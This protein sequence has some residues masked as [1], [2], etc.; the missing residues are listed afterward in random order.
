MF[1]VPHAST[2]LEWRAI[3]GD[4][5]A[6]H[7]PGLQQRSQMPATGANQAGQVL[8]QPG[9]APLPGPPTGQPPLLIQEQQPPQ[10]LRERIIVLQKGQQSIGRVEAANN[11][12]A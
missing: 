9:Q 6:M 3:T 10:L 11:H 2:D 4:G 7:G 5:S 1:L 8:R 12:D